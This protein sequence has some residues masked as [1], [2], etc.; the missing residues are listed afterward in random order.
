MFIYVLTLVCVLET[1]ISFPIDPKTPI[2][3][4]LSMYTEVKLAK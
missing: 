3:P 4:K 1:S 2:T